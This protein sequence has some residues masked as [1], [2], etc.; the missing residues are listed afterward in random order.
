[1]KQTSSLTRNLA[2]AQEQYAATHLYHHETLWRIYTEDV[3]GVDYVGAISRYFSG[4]TYTFSI[5]LWHSKRERSIVIDIVGTEADLQRVAWLAT[6]LKREA[7]Q[8]S[9]LVTASPCKTLEF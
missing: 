7:K 2:E 1:M 9:V 3:A 6:D 8:E 5:G 4:A